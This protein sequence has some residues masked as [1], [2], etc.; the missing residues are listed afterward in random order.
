MGFSRVVAVTIGPRL[1]PRDWSPN[2]R[3]IHIRTAPFA[4]ATSSNKAC[5]DARDLVDA[6][7]DDDQVPPDG[8]RLS[9]PSARLVLLYHH[10]TRLSAPSAPKR[11]GASFRVF[12]L[13]SCLLR[14]VKPD[15]P[16]S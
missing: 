4:R 14:T 8:A 3:P 13:R 9:R 10:P 2:Q 6:L 7:D 15:P 5:T 11:R 12:L 1:D 16:P